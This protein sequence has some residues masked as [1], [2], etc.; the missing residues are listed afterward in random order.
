MRITRALAALTLGLSLALTSCGN[1]ESSAGQRGGETSST[2][3]NDAD[4]AFASHMI[5]HH[6]Q[7]LAMVDMTVGRRLEP[8]VTGL[9]ESIRAAQGSEIQTMAEWL[10]EWDEPIP[11]T[12]RDHVNSG[13]HGSDHD[14]EID[15]P[16]TGMDLPGM[17]GDEDMSALE[18]ASHAEFEDLWL[19]M[20]VEHHEGAA[21]MAQ[22]E[23]ADGRY[24]PAVELAADI[25]KSQTA[26]I[27]LMQELLS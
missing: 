24:K 7:A 18:D 15:E 20:M 2:E 23:Q 12:V 27:D 9:A 22:A 5:Q 1:D 8:E 13:G 4:V 6:A 14:T 3:H 19:E 16:D 17:M 21:E 10:Q 25:E 26:E 11:A